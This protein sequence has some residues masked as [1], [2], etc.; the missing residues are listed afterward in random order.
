MI[1]NLRFEIQ[2]RLE[3]REVGTVSEDTHGTTYEWI[4]R[5]AHVPKGD[6]LQEL[7]E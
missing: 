5:H 6:V 3:P 1:V 4:P 7:R 2:E